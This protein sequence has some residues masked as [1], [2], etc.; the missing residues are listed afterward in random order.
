MLLSGTSGAVPYSYARYGQGIG[1][2]HVDN[3][4]CL[5]SE[6]TLSS[7]SYNNDTREDLHSQDWTITCR[8]GEQGVEIMYSTL[9]RNLVL[10]LL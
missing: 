4:Y 8:R 3:L 5:G 10:H 9:K 2:I 7:C 6:F 1:P